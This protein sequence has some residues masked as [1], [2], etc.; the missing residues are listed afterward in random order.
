VGQTKE[1]RLHAVAVVVVLLRKIK[2]VAK[3]IRNCL[4]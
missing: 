1:V 4:W 2:V 3:E